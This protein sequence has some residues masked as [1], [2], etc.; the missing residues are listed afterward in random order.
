[1]KRREHAQAPAPRKHSRQLNTLGGQL[2]AGCIELDIAQ[3]L[4]ATVLVVQQHLAHPESADA[5]QMLVVEPGNALGRQGRPV[6][7]KRKAASHERPLMADS[8][9]PRTSPPRTECR[10]VPAHRIVNAV[11]ARDHCA[12]C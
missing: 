7:V 6:Q 12:A 1:M 3:A 4:L 8:R 9:P 2:L 11:R 5:L 10:F